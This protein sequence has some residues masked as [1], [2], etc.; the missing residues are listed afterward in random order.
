MLLLALSF[1]YFYGY[2]SFTYYSICPDGSHCTA[3]PTSDLYKQIVAAW[4]I[5]GYLAVIA[6]LLLLARYGV[7][8][9]S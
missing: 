6:S 5:A 9:T 3:I 2:L 7:R 4:E 1:S 8:D